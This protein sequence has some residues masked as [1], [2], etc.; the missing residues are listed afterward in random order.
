VGDEKAQ[1]Q[2]NCPCANAFAQQKHF[3]AQKRRRHAAAAGRAG[4]RW[5]C[6]ALLPCQAIRDGYFSA[7][8]SPLDDEGL[9]L[10]VRMQV[11]M[12]AA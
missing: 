6:A 10:P 11:K 7:E 5:E 3:T 2:V 4:A 12:A 8:V 1:G 9:L